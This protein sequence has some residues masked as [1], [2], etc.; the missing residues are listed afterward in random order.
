MTVGIGMA[1]NYICS[2]EIFYK[3]MQYKLSHV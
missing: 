3:T 2:W 1:Y